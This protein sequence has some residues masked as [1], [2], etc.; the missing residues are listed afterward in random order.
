MSGEHRLELADSN[1]PT[2]PCPA[3][4]PT[5]LDDLPTLPSMPAVRLDVLTDILDN[6]ES[7]R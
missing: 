2:E 3:P 6:E 4:A 1:T 7:L 5:D